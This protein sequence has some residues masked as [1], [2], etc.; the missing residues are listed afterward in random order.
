MGTV[1]ITKVFDE[2]STI[3]VTMT[4]TD[5]G[6]NS[7]A[8]KTGTWTLTN[9]SGTVVNSRQDVAISTLS[10]TISVAVRSSDIVRAAGDDGTRYFLFEG[11]YDSD[12]GTDLPL[13]GRCR[14]TVADYHTI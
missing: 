12:L 13:T 14:L 5:D 8:P 2:G 7:V 10:S 6:G 3:K 1:K 11:T 4:F 9:A